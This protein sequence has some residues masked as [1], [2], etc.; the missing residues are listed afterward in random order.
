MECGRSRIHPEARTSRNRYKPHW[1]TI[2]MHT[3]CNLCAVLRVRRSARRSIPLPLQHVAVRLLPLMIPLHSIAPHPNHIMS[4]RN[5]P[6]DSDD[7]LRTPPSKKFRQ[8]P[9]T[10]ASSAR[11]CFPSSSASSSTSN[12]AVKH[13]VVS[14]DSDAAIHRQQGRKRLRKVEP[15]TDSEDNYNCVLRAAPVDEGDGDGS[16]E[17][18]IDHRPST[19]T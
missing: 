7:S 8:S 10:P 19:P 4:G 5:I 15:D 3:G 13:E 9:R 14:S 2:T 6:Q 12:T 1:P 16:P 11:H 18:T 17:N